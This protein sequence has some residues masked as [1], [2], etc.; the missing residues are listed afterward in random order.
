MAFQPINVITRY[1]NNCFYVLKSGYNA[2]YD[3]N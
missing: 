2:F 3:F 1:E